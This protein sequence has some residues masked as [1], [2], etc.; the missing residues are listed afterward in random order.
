MANNMLDVNTLYEQDQKLKKNEVE[1]LLEWCKQQRHFPKIM[2]LQAA[3]ALHACFYSIE[4]A[5][6]CLEHFFTIRGLCP[7]L[8]GHANPETNAAFREALNVSFIGILPEKTKEGYVVVLTKLMNTNT[9]VYNPQIDFKITDMHILRH[10][11]VEGPGNGF[12]LIIDMKG[13]V[14]GHM[15]KLNLS[16]TKK[17]MVYLQ[18]AL[19]IRLMYV[20]FINVVPFM[21]KLLAVLKPFINKEMFSKLMVHT[22]NNNLYKYV[23]LECMPEDYGGKAPS[24]DI[25]FE[26]S[27]QTIY[28]NKWFYDYHDT[29]VAD[30]SKRIGPRKN[31]DSLFGFD[32]T[33]K[34]LSVD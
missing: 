1:M 8:L 7:E 19:P 29:M 4:Q 2:E 18:S 17:N 32:G 23:P 11:H 27:K 10:I 34:K 30:E 20:H 3:L 24:I 21:D 13:G 16:E 31:V 15:T 22:N 6:S 5:K 33:F 28:D 26:K 14:F 25:L 9:E 12:V